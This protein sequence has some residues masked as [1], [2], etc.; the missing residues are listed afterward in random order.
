MRCP[1]CCNPEMLAFVDRSARDP[2]E[3]AGEALEAGVEG[4]TFLGGEPFAQ[5]EAFAEIAE[6]VRARGLSVM[7]FSGYTL[8]E[9]HA[10]SDPAVERLLSGTDLLVDGRY[11]EACEQYRRLVAR[12]SLDFTAW[13]G[14]GDC[15]RFDRLVV[16]EAA[17]PSTWRG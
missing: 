1:G 5:P 7:I 13:F 14:L 3:I 9:L 8:A 12:D 16:R 15:N 17:S 10:L 4:V 11:V 2:L 6:R